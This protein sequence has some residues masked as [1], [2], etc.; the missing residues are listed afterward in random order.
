MIGISHTVR[1][2]PCQPGDGA[3]VH[4]ENPGDGAAALGGGQ[5]LECLSLL[6]A[7]ERGPAGDVCR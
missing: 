6:V 3:M 7:T 2:L 5:A 4:V 1:G